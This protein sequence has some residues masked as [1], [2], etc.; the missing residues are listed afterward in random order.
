MA[1]K[2]MQLVADLET[3]TDPKDVR[4]WAVSAVDIPTQETVFLS[5][6]LPEFMKWLE[7]K[8]TIVYFHNARFDLEFVLPY[9]FWNG[10]KHI[11]EVQP[12]PKDGKRRAGVPGTFDT[13]ITDDGIVYSLTVYFSQKKK[14]WNKV[15]FYDSLKKLPFKVS[16]IAKAFQLEDQKLEIDYDAYR[17]KG[18]ELTEKEKNYVVTD[19][20]IVASALNIQ[21]SK[22]LTKMTNASDAMAWYKDSLRGQF[23][24]YYPVLPLDIDKE[25][26]RTY[27]GGYVYLNPK[28]RG[29][30]GLQG[31]TFDVNSLYPSVMYQKLLPYGYP[32]HFEG[33][34][35]PDENYP[36]YIVKLRCSFKVKKGH[37]PTLQL[38]N[39]RSHF[40]ETEYITTSKGAIV[41]FSLTSVDLKLF[42][43][44]YDVLNLEYINGY[45]F[46][47]AHDLFKEYIDYWMHIKETETGSIKQLAKLMLNSL[48]GRFCLN[49]ET[50]QKIPYMDTDNVV[51]YKLDDPELRDPV[52]TAMGSFITSYA[53]EKTI[54]TAQSLGDRFIYADT[55]SCHIVGYEVPEDM[56]IHPTR[57]GAWK[58]EGLFTDSMFIR[59]KT[60]ME[61][62]DGKNKV[63]CAGMPDNIKELVTYDNFH[64]GS[65]FDGKLMPRRFPGGIVLMPT[66]FT[67]K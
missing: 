46:K 9:L 23:E 12:K 32:K 45:K 8:N 57:L 15:V 2:T 51:R 56:D 67:I 10:Y 37:L 11:S 39:H 1:T 35:E 17:P 38:K 64:P 21:F 61:T 66:T 62:V 16:Q 28:Y 58:N 27:K 26:R 47:G 36:L 41:E 34:Y 18:H 49:P 52:Y 48:Y 65:T 25:I 63:T 54:R 50:R 33:E 14:K 24:R 31:I 44:H 20:R 55:D 42:L 5:N 13:L 43:D 29:V 59:A 19:A 30:R 6:S 4:A 7:N 40:V 22:S 3:T 60:Y 53:R